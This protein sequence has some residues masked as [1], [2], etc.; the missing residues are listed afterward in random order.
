M[1]SSTN[2][3]AV[4]VDRSG[5]LEVLGSGMVTIIDGRSVVSD[6]FAREVGEVLTVVNSHLCAFGPGQAFGLN[7]RQPLPFETG[8]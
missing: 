7:S 1:S 4:L 2:T 5:K 8:T 3:S 6:Y